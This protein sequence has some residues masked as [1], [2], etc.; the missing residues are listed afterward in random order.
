MAEPTSEILLNE[1][2]SAVAT[3]QPGD[4]RVY[5]ASQWKLVW[6][7]FKSHRLALISLAVLLILY[8]VVLFAPFLAP[9]DPLKRDSKNIYVPPQRLHFIHEGDFSLRP[10]VYKYDQTIDL[11]TLER[12]NVPDTSTPYSV[13]FFVRG[14]E[15]KLLRI[16]ETNIHLFGVD[17][18]GTIYL[19]GTDEFGRD[20]LSRLIMG[21]QISLSIGLVGIFFS[22]ILGMVLG[23]VSGYYG[24]GA[25]TLIQRLIELLL[26]LPTIPLWM[27]LAAILPVE[28]PTVRIY[29]MITLILSL[30][31]W[32]QIA[33]VVR[34]KLLSVREEDFVMA[35]R[36][37]GAREGRIIGR[38]LLPSTFSYLIV[39]LTLAVPTMIL[40]ETALSFLGLG[41]QPP[42]VSWGVLLQQAQ[43]VRTIALYPWLLA[44]AALVILTVLCFNFVGDGL[45]D[46]ADPYVR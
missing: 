5:V 38:H 10:F 22:F 18:G 32:P 23:G 39:A 17:Q 35:A 11:E 45:R 33:R 14:S 43:N 30:L 40:S 15:Y 28:W 20:F 3:E 31:A 26:C 9:S 29:F 21:A 24:G 1:P 16:F 2:T 44:P 36:L 4:E 7:K 6:W 42:V 41:L 34:G 27:A 12:V 37:A 8:L 46:A 19:L 13:R 25:D